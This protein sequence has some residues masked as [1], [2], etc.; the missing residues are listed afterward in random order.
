MK[1]LQHK[2]QFPVHEEQKDSDHDQT[3]MKPFLF[4]DDAFFQGFMNFVF[5]FLA[6]SF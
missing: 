6:I 2:Q 4:S 3:Q 1:D 5:D